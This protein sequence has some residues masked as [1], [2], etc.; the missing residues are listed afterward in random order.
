MNNRAFFFGR[1]LLRFVLSMCALAST[2]TTA[3]TPQVVGQWANGPN[4]PYFPIHINLLPNSTVM[5]SSV[6]ITVAAPSCLLRQD[7]VRA[8]SVS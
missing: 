4:L 7:G 8:N 1:M 3:Q 5:F 2:W 6:N